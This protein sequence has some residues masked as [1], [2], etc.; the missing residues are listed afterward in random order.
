M[1]ILTGFSQVNS[2][3]GLESSLLLVPSLKVKF[4]HSTYTSSISVL[5]SST[6]RLETLSVQ[7]LAGE[8]LLTF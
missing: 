4:V 6:N 1:S 8:D 5:N 7:Y 3:L 2:N